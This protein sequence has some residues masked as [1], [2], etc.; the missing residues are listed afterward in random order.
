MGLRGLCDKLQTGIRLRSI[1]LAQG[2]TVSKPAGLFCKPVGQIIRHLCGF[3]FRKPP[4]GHQRGEISAIDAPCHIVAGRD[5]TKGAGIVIKSD[6]ILKTCCFRDGFS[7]AAHAFGAVVKPPRR[8]QFQRWIHPCKRRQFGRKRGLVQ[9]KDD[10]D[11]TRLRPPPHST[12][13]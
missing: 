9:G 7:R 2:K 13:A 10:D 6:G 4:R 5:R 11:Q 12:V 8:P 3:V 1:G